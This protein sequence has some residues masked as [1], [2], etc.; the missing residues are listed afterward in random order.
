MRL[1]RL[2]HP[3]SVAI[4][5]ASDRPETYA[6]QTLLNLA[7]TGY[8]GEV[9]GVNP[10]RTS[11]H[12][13]PCVPSLRELPAPPDAVVVAIPA[14]GVPAVIEEAGALGC[15]G[16]VV[17]AAGFGEATGVALQDALVASARR[18]GMPVC[19]PNCDGLVAGAALWGDALV[20]APRGHV[21]LVSQ[22]GNLVVNA[23]ATRRGLRL[24]TAVSSGNE[25]VVTTAD[26]IAALGRE[27]GVRS[28]AVLVEAEGD[29][30]ALCEAL[31][32]CAERGV[33][34]AVLKV[35]ASA[36]GA[37]AAAAHT[38]SVA[39]DHRVFRALMEE[40]GA[41][42]A[43]DVHELLELAKALAATGPRP[44]RAG[45]AVL[46][47]SGGDSG[48]AA[49]EAARRGVA[50]PAFSGETSAALRD[51][52]P[53]AATAAN[54][55]DHTALIWGDAAVQRELLRV[56]GSDPAVGQTLV[57]FDQPPGLDGYQGESWAAHAQGILEGAS[58]SDVGVLVAATLPELLDDDA[59]WAFAQAGIPAV[60]G[61]R[62]GIACAAALATPA[63][64]PAR[65]RT[66]GAQRGR[67]LH[68]STRSDC[69]QPGPP[70]C[71]NARYDPAWLAEHEAKA[72]LRAAGVPVVEGRIAR[73]EDDAVAAAEELGGPVALKRSAAGLLH[74]AA[75]GALALNV[76]V[77]AVR[78]A[79][80]S[81]ANGDSQLLVERMAAPGAELLVAVRRD[82]VV[83]ALVVGLGGAH[84]EVL[85]DVQVIPLPADPARIER[86]IRRLRGAPLLAGAD[87]AAAAT[88]AASLTH[89]DHLEL[90]ECNPVLVHESGAVVVDA[91]AKEIAP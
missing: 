66:I 39:G 91:V 14:P 88:L 10:R 52:L 11:V 69:G 51:R 26:W 15:G 49:D 4:V 45:L 12:G 17:F 33:R 83:P 9:W 60:A 65:L 56:V 2:L 1:D 81:I 41:A 84:A 67:I 22:S 37:A 74:K 20:P 6:N 61:L 78:D 3:R 25:A 31:A 59:A 34:V 62:A 89:F 80:R 58:A 90:L 53:D 19:G 28:I 76:E 79:Y 8:D 48:L 82:A 40:A 63:P 23:L 54:P 44:R 64:D 16:A 21:A 68:S 70:G 29:G 77:D 27:E 47:C 18:H 75:V 71:S 72:L 32:V 43:E 85:D 42:W 38:G 86:A 57:C 13:R 55:L 36:V 35:G 30:A 24:H 5:G 50:L 7:A 87:L 46:T 73:G